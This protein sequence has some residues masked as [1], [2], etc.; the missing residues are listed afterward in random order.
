MNGAEAWLMRKL[1]ERTII[2]LCL[3]YKFY[4]DF[5]RKKFTNLMN[6]R[7][8]MKFLISRSKKYFFY[9]PKKVYNMIME[10]KHNQNKKN[11]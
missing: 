2:R 4:V 1:Y 8:M 3:N 5:I 7:K 11:I 6:E 9:V 10:N